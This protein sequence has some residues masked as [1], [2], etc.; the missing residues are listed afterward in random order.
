VA[1]CTSVVRIP[2]SV[3]R[4]CGRRIHPFYDA[5]ARKE[6]GGEAGSKVGSNS[7]IAGKSDTAYKELATRQ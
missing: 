4:Y 2:K 6:G 3:H 7:V 1:L 5:E